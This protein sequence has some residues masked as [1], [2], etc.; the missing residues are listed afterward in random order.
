L[1][2]LILYMS[3]SSIQHSSPIS[4]L[5]SSSHHL[6]PKTGPPIMRKMTNETLKAELG[7][8]TWRYF[9]TVMAQYPKKPSSQQMET[10][11][12]FVGLF[13]Q[14]Y[15]CGQCAE[16]FQ[17]LTQRYPPQLQGKSEA[18]IWACHVHNKVNEALGKDWFDCS[19]VLAK[20]DC[21]CGEQEGDT[22]DSEDEEEER[23]EKASL[24]VEVQTEGLT[25]GG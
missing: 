15:P 3:T 24:K 20:Y 11:A 13:A 9:H 1:V 23:K 17:A 25:R 18:S 16:H 2:V 21:G 8:A 4:S 5:Q 14:T 22:D 12:A 19:Q 6:I 7:R 10:L